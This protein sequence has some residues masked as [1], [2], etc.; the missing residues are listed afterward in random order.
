M[1]KLKSKTFSQVKFGKF[2]WFDVDAASE[3]KSCAFANVSSYLTH[4]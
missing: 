4:K 3:E 2:F 1:E